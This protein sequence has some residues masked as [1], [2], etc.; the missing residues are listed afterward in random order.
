[1]ASS[2]QK[3]DLF[4]PVR[5]RW[6]KETPEER[7][8]QGWIQKMVAELEF[9]LSLLSIEKELSSLPHLYHLNQQ[10]IP[11]RRIDIVAFGKKR[12]GSLFPLLMIECKAYPLNDKFASQVIGYNAFVQ[13]PFIAIANEHQI[14]TGSYDSTKKHFV[15]QSGL[16]SY[17]HLLNALQ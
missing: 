13:A 14:M 4:D 15:F 3:C 12:G 11:H 1:M 10:E 9:P 16:S 8:R 5:K 2:N 7:I 6:I 17:P